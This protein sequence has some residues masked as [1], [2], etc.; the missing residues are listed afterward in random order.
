M[1]KPLRDKLGLNVIE[2]KLK[3][4]RILKNYPDKGNNLTTVNTIKE[5]LQ[6]YGSYE[7]TLGNYKLMTVYKED[8]K[9]IR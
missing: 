9:E 7:L 3:S 4:G 2:V 5:H 8:V 6:T 1:K